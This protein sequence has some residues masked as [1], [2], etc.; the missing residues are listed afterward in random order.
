MNVLSNEKL[1]MYSDKYVT[2]DINDV[3]RNMLN[4]TKIS[5]LVQRGE[6]RRDIQNVFSIDIKTM[7]ATYQKQSGRCWIFAGC[8]FLREIVAKKYNLDNFELS[9]SYIAFYDKLEKCNY[10]I[11]TI[12]ELLSRNDSDI[13][14]DRLISYILNR[15][16]EDGGQ[17]NMFVNIVKKYGI[18]P[19]S[20]YDETYQSSNTREVNILLNRLLRKYASEVVSK[21]DDNLK[22]KYM[23]DIYRILVDCY[24]IIPQKFN[25]EYQDKDGEYKIVRDLTPL[26]FFDSFVDVNLDDY[27][28]IINSPTVDKPFNEMYMVKYLGNVVE[29]SNILYLN[30][31]MGQFKEIVI[32]QLSDLCPV[33]FGSDCSSYGDRQI[34]FWD[35]DSFE[36]NKIFDTDFNIS[37]DKMLD[38]RESAMNHAMLFT[39]VNIVDS[40]PTRWKIENS[41]GEKNGFKGYYVASDGWFDR[42]VYQAVVN[43]KYLNDF[44]LQCLDKVPYELDPWDPMGTLA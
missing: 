34:G 18:V 14:N 3:V 42:Y 10:F 9:Q 39:G 37:K 29:G 26:S 31:D 17:W 4:K 30:L 8:N 11:N 7:S 16:I 44:Q 27:V 35:T 28:S 43:K 25:F 2:N 15:G 12:D 38:F 22:N 19:K 5:D 33:W 32:K 23:E 24:G 6:K 1:K 40:K 13:R 36:Y 41:W 20:V 21:K